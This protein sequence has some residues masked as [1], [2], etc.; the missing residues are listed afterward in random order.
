MENWIVYVCLG[1][2]FLSALVAGVFQSFSDFVM[3]GL[4]R[5]TDAGGIESMQHI[6]R[7]VFRSVFLVSFLSLVPLSIAFAFY[8]GLRLDGHGRFFVFAASITYVTT[9]FLVTV[10]RNVPMNER[11]DRMD[12]V[13]AEAVRYWQTY[14][15]RWTRFNHLRTVGSAATAAFFLLAAAGFSSAM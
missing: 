4:A 13:S 8:A 10:L 14:C 7:T 3:A 6:N 15:R 1:F 5:A 11:L 9:V 2:G 12:P